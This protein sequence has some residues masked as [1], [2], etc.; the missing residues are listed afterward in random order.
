MESLPDSAVVGVLLAIEGELTPARRRQL[1]RCGLRI[2]S[3][4][5]GIVTGEARRGSLGRLAAL[6][7]VAYI[8]VPEALPVPP[9]PLR[10][11]PQ[12]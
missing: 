8:E 10:P 12:H 3:V 1:E 5:E 11:S 7:F 2:G 9:F 6:D 4:L